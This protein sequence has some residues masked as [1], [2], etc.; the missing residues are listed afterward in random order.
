[1]LRPWIE[2]I[3][4]AKRYGLRVAV[5]NFRFELGAWIG[6]FE[7]CD[8][9]TDEEIVEEHRAEIIR[10]AAERQAITS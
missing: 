6:G 4:S 8:N 9:Y 3:S 7:H 2:L 1:M 10:R 5:K